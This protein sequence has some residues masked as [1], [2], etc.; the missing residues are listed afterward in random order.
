MLDK[1]KTAFVLLLIGAFSGGLI[2]I[3]NEITAPI[4]EENELNRKIAFYSEI[5][6]QEEVV[7]KDCT[8]DATLLVPSEGQTEDDITYELRDV[9]PSDVSETYIY[10][11]N[12]TYLGAVY[13]GSEVNSYGD[14]SVLVG[15]NSDG[16]ISMVVISGS[17]NTPNF[18]KRIENNNLEKFSTYTV[19]NVEFDSSTG[20]TYTYTSVSNIVKLAIEA[21]NEGSEE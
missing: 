16:A 10:D 8:T 19:D 2:Y 17:T 15:I 12:G 3:V 4:I 9:C 14:I 6:D 20:A 11:V 5:F 21:Y 13:E 7:F 18:V 1:M